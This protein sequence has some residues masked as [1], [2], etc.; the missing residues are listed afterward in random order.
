MV[1]AQVAAKEKMDAEK[2]RKKKT[3]AAET[4]ETFYG[5]PIAGRLPLWTA[6]QPLRLPPNGHQVI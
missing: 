6:E 5:P 4:D 3:T 2:K 1:A